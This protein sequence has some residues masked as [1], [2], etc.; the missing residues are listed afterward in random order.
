MHHPGISMTCH[1]CP[2][3]LARALGGTVGKNP[4]GRFVLTGWD[5]VSECASNNMRVCTA[6]SGSQKGV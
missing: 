3:I 5:L 2:Q 4:S 6:A 1:T